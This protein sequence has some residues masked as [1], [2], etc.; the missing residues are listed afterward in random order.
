MDAVRSNERGSD[1]QAC[2]SHLLCALI[3]SDAETIAAHEAFAAILAALAV[4]ETAFVWVDLAPPG[5]T[6]LFIFVCA[7]SG[8][9]E[10]DLARTHDA[11]LI[12]DMCGGTSSIRAAWRCGGCGT[13]HAPRISPF[14]R[15][16]NLFVDRCAV[17]GTRASAMACSHCGVPI[18]LEPTTCDCGRGAIGRFVDGAESYGGSQHGV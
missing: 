12:C 8:V 2:C 3:R 10:L 4:A 13:E 17:C 11:S 16:R 6:S 15:I 9:W 7:L 18:V 1:Q 14:A 5:L